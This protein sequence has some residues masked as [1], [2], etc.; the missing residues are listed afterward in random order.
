[1]RELLEEIQDSENGQSEAAPARDG[2]AEI[3]AAR[4]ALLALRE[5][6]DQE[7]RRISEEFERMRAD[8]QSFESDR[9]QVLSLL[10][11]LRDEQ[12]TRATRQPQL[13]PADVAAAGNEGSRES[14]VAENLTPA[15]TGDLG[16]TENE[17]LS[18]LLAA[19]KTAS[20]RA[21]P[22]AA[23]AAAGSVI[24][25]GPAATD[26]HEIEQYMSRLLARQRPR[27]DGEPLNLDP[28][29]ADGGATQPPS[30]FEV[31]DAAQPQPAAPASRRRPRPRP[32]SAEARA[33]LKVL[34]E[35]ANESMRSAM[36]RHHVRRHWPNVFVKL[37]LV[38]VAFV[39]M[40]VLL[41]DHGPTRDAF[42]ALGWG[43]GAIGSITIAS[44]VY[45]YDRNIRRISLFRRGEARDVPEEPPE[46][47]AAA[48]TARPQTR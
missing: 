37:V 33:G 44:L 34:R 1:M 7:R 13:P 27:R 39:L 2:L 12:A 19:Q 15:A 48:P 31:P 46:T 30:Q 24:Q 41:W 26:K 28:Y 16:G 45:S 23:D 43:A 18:R 22:E 3:E 11:T 9:R 40:T 42:S 17:R 35:V 32:N 14:E 36:A 21:L 29:P 10:Q 5:S 47:P 8:R 20:D 4:T 6:F 38:A 25:S